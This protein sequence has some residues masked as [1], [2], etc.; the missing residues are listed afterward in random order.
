M[1]LDGLG[2]TSCHICSKS[3]YLNVASINDLTSVSCLTQSER[4]SPPADNHNTA[5]EFDPSVHGFDGMVHTSLPG[6]PAPGDSMFL[7]VPNQLPA[8]FPFLLDMNA[9]RPLGLGTFRPYFTRGFQCY[10]TFAR[11]AGT[12]ELLETG[13]EAAPRL[14]TS[15]RNLPAEIICTWS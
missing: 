8:K 2:K 9:G 14:P 13:Q 6:N 15:P 11:K 4:W 7:T 3:E 5:G 10:F 1:T 12:R